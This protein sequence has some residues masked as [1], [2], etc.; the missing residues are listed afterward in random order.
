MTTK[1]QILIQAAICALNIVYGLIAYRFATFYYVA[2]IFIYAIVSGVIV[3][4][5]I[6]TI[7][8]WRSLDIAWASLNVL[9]IVLAFLMVLSGIGHLASIALNGWYPPF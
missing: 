1:R 3:A 4:L 8:Q 2:G 9:T 5:G 6:R 7:R